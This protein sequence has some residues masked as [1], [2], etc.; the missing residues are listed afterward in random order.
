MF[1]HIPKT[2]GT[3]LNEVALNHSIYWMWMLFGTAEGRE[4]TKAF[5]AEFCD[6]QEYQ[7]CAGVEINPWHVP[8][9]WWTE[10][11]MRNASKQGNNTLQWYFD[12]ANTDWFAI[13]R[14]PF[15]K[16]VSEYKWRTSLWNQ[17]TNCS[18][19]GMNRWMADNLRENLCNHMTPFTE[20]IFDSTGK[21][22]VKHVIRFEN[23]KEEL[24]KLFSEYNLDGVYREWLHTHSNRG[25]CPN[26]KG[27]MISEENKEIIRV[28][29]KDDFD[30]FQYSMEI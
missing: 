23:V 19:D 14:N 22:I 20:F 17:T 28:R 3:T 25:S 7:F 8:L 29:Y 21:Q 10:Y 24:A 4:W 6:R 16:M 13:V 2:G 30:K 27:S 15:N 11:F 1:M 26:L 9:R 5:K 18:V 12:P